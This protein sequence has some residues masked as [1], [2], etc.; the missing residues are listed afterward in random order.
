MGG[1]G[2][3]GGGNEAQIRL[4][5]FIQG[6]GDANDDRVHLRELRVVRSG[7]ETGLPGT[8]NLFGGDAENV[9]PAGVERVDLALIDIETG[10]A[11]FLL[12]VKQSQG[13]SHIA[14]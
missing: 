8:A 10:D 3:S 5:V 4:V 9:R 1:N 12:T 7:L 13:Q 2:V 11:E 14:K 6:S